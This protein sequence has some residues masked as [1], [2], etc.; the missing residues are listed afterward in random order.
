MAQ[1]DD[2]PSTD[3]VIP[4]RVVTAKPPLDDEAAL[5]QIRDLPPGEVNATKLAA[6]WGWSRSRVRRQVDQWRVEGQL[7][8]PGRSRRGRAPVPATT[9]ATKPATLPASE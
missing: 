6:A 8:R 1:V 9:P 4:L 7:R 5:A 3:T 2:H